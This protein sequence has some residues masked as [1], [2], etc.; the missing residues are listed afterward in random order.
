VFVVPKYMLPY[1][2][3]PYFV[4]VSLLRQT[5]GLFVPHSKCTGRTVHILPLTTCLLGIL[6]SCVTPAL[7]GWFI[8]NFLSWICDLKSVSWYLILYFLFVLPA[9]LFLQNC[10]PF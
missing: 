5:C 4:S 1:W 9:V 6:S 2:Y 3:L 10:T 7:Y 8:D